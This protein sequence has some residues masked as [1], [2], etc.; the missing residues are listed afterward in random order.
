MQNVYKKTSED[1]GSSQYRCRHK[2]LQNEVIVDGVTYKIFS[3]TARP[4]CDYK[5]KKVSELLA[6][7]ANGK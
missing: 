7:L 5:P 2:Y 4:D 6:Y 3:V 1:I